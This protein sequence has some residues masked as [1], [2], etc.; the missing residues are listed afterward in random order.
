VCATLT[1]ASAADDSR[2]LLDA[3]EAWVRE[4]P[5]SS[6][7]PQAQAAELLADLR[8]DRRFWLQQRKQ[9]SRIWGAIEQQVREEER[10]LRD[11]LGSETSARLL[12]ALEEMQDD[13]DTVHAALRSEVVYKVLGKVLYEGIFE[14]MQVRDRSLHSISASLT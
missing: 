11:V 3:L 14:F 8:D 7:L 9:F 5:V 13:A 6:I 10:P 2:A 12:S 1:S 4:Q